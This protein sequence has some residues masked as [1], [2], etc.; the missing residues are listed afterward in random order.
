MCFS[1]LRSERA[2]ENE[3]LV[4]RHVLDEMKLFHEK[5]IGSLKVRIDLEFKGLKKYILVY[6]NVLLCQRKC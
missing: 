1:Q 2:E 4:G 5:E 6:R 3:E